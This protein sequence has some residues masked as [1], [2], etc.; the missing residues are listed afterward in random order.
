MAVVFVL[1]SEQVHC[2]KIVEL[3]RHSECCRRPI[4]QG[5]GKWLNTSA[6]LESSGE[7][8]ILAQNEGEAPSLF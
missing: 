8:G 2:K 7:I 5:D 6:K 4:Y 3:V 1:D